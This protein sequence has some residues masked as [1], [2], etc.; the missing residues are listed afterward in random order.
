VRKAADTGL[1]GGAIYDALIAAT[2]RHAGT[3]LLTQDQRAR[4]VHERVGFRHEL[5]G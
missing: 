4:P 1:A 5:V 2:A 3:T